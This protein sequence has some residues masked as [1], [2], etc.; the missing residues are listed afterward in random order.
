MMKR[1]RGKRD[2]IRYKDASHLM[3]GTGPGITKISQAGFTMDFGG[4]AEGTAAARADAWARV[5]RF[6]AEV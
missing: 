3:M 5:K 4:T 1:W 2:H 6:M